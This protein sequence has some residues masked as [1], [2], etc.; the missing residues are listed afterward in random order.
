VAVIEH[1]G[2]VPIRKGRVRRFA[3]DAAVSACPMDL[4]PGNDG[5]PTDL[6]V[7]IGAAP[8]RR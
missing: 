4:N 5:R 6:L 1:S 8:T 3:A 2:S 7:R